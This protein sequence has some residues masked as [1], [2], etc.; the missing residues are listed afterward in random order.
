[1]SKAWDQIINDGIELKKIS[2]MPDGDEKYEAV[3]N[4]V[5]S[6]DVKVTMEVLM[7]SG[8]PSS[9]YT[10]TGTREHG[11]ERAVAWWHWG[12]DTSD[13]PVSE[14]ADPDLWAWLEGT[15]D[16]RTERA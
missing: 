8:G 10:L 2:D 5:L 6:V 9:G 14:E 16:L 4:G 12:T 7:Q 13:F 11:M 1:M 3:E 15:F